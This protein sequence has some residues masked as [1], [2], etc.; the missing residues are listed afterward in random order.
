MPLYMTVVN[1]GV[2][3]VLFTEGRLVNDALLRQA[4]QELI[5]VMNK[6]EQGKLLINFERVKFMASAMLGQLVNLH[7]QCKAAKVELKLCSIAPEI[8]EVF[9]LTRLDAV[10]DIQDTEARALAAFAGGGK[11]WFG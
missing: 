3:I 4:G 6:S 5:K 10:F 9:K 11:G 1:Q 8:L 2:D 7:K